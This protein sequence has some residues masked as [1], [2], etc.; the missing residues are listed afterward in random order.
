MVESDKYSANVQTNSEV[1]LH[2]SGDAVLLHVG[3]PEQRG[4]QHF[5]TDIMGK[6]N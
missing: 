6:T 1:L 3:A 4:M 2:P 5:Q